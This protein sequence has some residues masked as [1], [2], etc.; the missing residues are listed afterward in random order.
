MRRLGVREQ[1]TIGKLAR[2]MWL[3]I[4]RR[5]LRIQYDGITSRRAEILTNFAQPMRRV[6]PLS[7][8]HLYKSRGF[9]QLNKRKCYDFKIKPFGFLQAV[10]PA[11]EFRK[12]AAQPIA[13]FERGLVE[14][15]TCLGAT[16]EPGEAVSLDWEGNAYA[17][18]IP[19]TRFDEFISGYA[20]HP[21]SKAAASDGTPANEDSRGVLGRLHLAGGAPRRIGKEM[22]R[23]DEDEDFTLDRPDPAEYQNAETTLKWALE[24]LAKE[25]ASRVAKLVGMSERR[26]RDIRS[27]HVKKVRR[28]HREAIIRL[29]VGSPS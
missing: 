22:D 25:P 1:E 8:P 13:P 19:V 7:K 20:R 3:R 29:A 12:K 4:L 21:E 11:L 16:T 15:K 17:E 18:T 9:T 28:N 5:E 23:L 24:V 6:L 14:S 10:T 27:G 26:F 2:R